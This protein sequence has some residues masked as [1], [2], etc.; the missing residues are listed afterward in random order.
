[1]ELVFNVFQ[2]AAMYI[3]PAAT[4]VLITSISGIIVAVGTVAILMWRKTKKR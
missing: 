2:P 3:D 4:S 1:M